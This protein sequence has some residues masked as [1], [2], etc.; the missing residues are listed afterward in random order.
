MQC[1]RAGAISDPLLAAPK[2]MAR[3]T[4]CPERM[5]AQAGPSSLA[6]IP[7][8]PL[9]LRVYLSRC[10]VIWKGASIVSLDVSKLRAVGLI[11][12][13]TWRNW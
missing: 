2:P 9:F 12:Q 8:I 5:D 11:I 4:A 10:L 13:G 1:L 6:G 7:D 3:T